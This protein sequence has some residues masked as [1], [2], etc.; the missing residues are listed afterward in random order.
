MKNMTI[1]GDNNDE[2]MQ[3]TRGNDVMSK[4]MYR[5][6]MTGIEKFC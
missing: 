5:C 3:G 4:C 6:S 1:K 2:T